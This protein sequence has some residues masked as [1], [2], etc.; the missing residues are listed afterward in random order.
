MNF[1]FDLIRSTNWA[2]SVISRNLVVS[3]KFKQK[4]VI[5]YAQFSYKA[6]LSEFPLVRSR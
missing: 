4:F 5:A 2:E 6:L 3:T 1:F